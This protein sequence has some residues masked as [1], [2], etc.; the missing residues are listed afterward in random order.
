MRRF[1]VMAAIAWTVSGCGWITEW[2]SGT[3]NSP[4]PAPLQAVANPIPF[5]KVWDTRVGAGTDGAFVK[6]VPALDQGG[7]LYAA[8]RDGEVVALDAGSG[9]ARWKVATKLPIS[10]GVGVGDGLAVV[11]TSKGEVVALRTDSGNEAWR[12][13]VSSEV[14]APPRIAEGVVVIRAA[15]GRFFG[16]E[17]ASGRQIWG[18][19]ST[20]PVLTLRGSAPPLVGQGVV[21]AGL[22][23]GRVLGLDLRSGRPVFER[24]VAAPRGRTEM[25]RLVDIDA[26]PRAAGSTLYIAPY[27]GSVT[28]ID[29]Q[30]GNPVWAKDISTYAGLDIDPQAVYVVGADDTVSA[31]DRRDGSVLWQQA[32]L[33]GRHLS[34]PTVYGP[35]IALADFEGYVHLL[36]SRSGRIVGRAQIDSTGVG[37]GPLARGNMLYVYGKS[38]TLAAY[39]AG[40]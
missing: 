29:L 37:V 19:A 2:V 16:F 22:E 40:G 27:H 4:P 15:D 9:Q 28:A 3:D 10:G 11:A 8:S 32:E 21:I 7:G 24:V 18:Y 6:L 39:R 13:R 20:V 31:L 26:E 17:V 38:G 35:L 25:D 14:L 23:S 30:S 12:A 5:S 34:A 36:D 1:I 33:S